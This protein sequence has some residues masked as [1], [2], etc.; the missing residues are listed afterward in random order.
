MTKRP[1]MPVNRG[2]LGMA[3]DLDNFNQKNK[4][5]DQSAENL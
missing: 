4:R 3:Q 2:K 5:Y 1:E